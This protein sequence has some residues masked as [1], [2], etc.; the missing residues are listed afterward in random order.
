MTIAVELGG[1]N[2]ALLLPGV[3]FVINRDYIE[4]NKTV[5]M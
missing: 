4:H 1:K 2:F 5:L 3:I